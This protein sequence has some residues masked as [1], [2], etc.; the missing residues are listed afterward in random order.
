MLTE[1]SG[2]ADGKVTDTFVVLA[3]GFSVGTRKVSLVKPP[4]AASRGLT[5]TCADAEPASSTEP[6][7]AASVVPTPRVARRRRQG[8]LEVNIGH[9]PLVRGLHR[10]RRPVDGRR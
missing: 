3:S 1:A 6:V 4:G 5:V 8:W 9:G 2:V 10:S 7:R